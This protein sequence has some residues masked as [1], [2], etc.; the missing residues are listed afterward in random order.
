QLSIMY[1][2]AGER[3]LPELELQ[4]LPGYERSSPL[5][6]GNDASKQRQLDVFGE[7]LDSFWI[8]R[9]MG[10]P[11]PQTAW[12]L[13]IELLEY[14]E[15]A[16]RDP[17]EGIWEI[18][19]APQHFTHSKVMAWVAFDRAVKGMELLGRKGPLDR[20]KQAREDLRKEILAKGYDAERGT[21]VQHYG[22]KELD[23]SLLLLPLVGFL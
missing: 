22:S 23:A 4:W 18:R 20:F 3:W 2:P 14:L 7:V 15:T 5:R 17:D 9:R 19:G 12:A 10:I 6:I 8:A 1:G 11:V 13:C 16:W 21:F